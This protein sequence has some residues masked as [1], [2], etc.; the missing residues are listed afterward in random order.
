TLDVGGTSTDVSLVQGLMPQLTSASF[1]ESYPVKTP[2]LDIITV[3]T[4][5]GSIAWV[6]AYGG[7]KVGP[8]SAGADPGPICYGR[9][10]TKP[11]VTDAALVLGR[12]PGELIGGELPLDPAAARDAFGALGK[13]FDMAPEAAAAGVFEIAAANQVHGIRQVTTTR[14]RDPGLYTLVAFGGAGGMF[15]AEVA[16]FLNIRTV[17][18]PPNPGNLSAFGLHVSDI[19]RDYIRTLVRPQ[20]SAEADEIERVWREL[21]E[22]GRKEI[23]QEGVAAGDIELV[24]LADLRYV[25][26]G[27]EVP[28]AIPGGRVGG[29]ALEAMWSS[30]HHVHEETFGFAYRGEQDVELVNLRV[31]AIGRVNRPK[32]AEIEPNGADPEPAGR[33]RVYWRGMG[34]IDCPI[35]RRDEL[36]AGARLEGPAILEEYGSTV[37]VPQSWRMAVDRHGILKLEKMR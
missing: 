8:Q 34:W 9:G 30:F 36:G 32:V 10:G 25:G 21:E 7:L 6:D 23:T 3:G 31:Q 1:V 13:T 11:T 24:R 37:V 2:M 17:L 18:S 20:S 5:G 27:Y 12:L 28:V 26:E 33:R 29:D 35:Y 14:G 19:K 15:A 16:D 4:G 22:Q